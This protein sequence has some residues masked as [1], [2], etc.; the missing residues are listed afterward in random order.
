MF[1]GI[2]QFRSMI[3]RRFQQD[4]QTT[5]CENKA[6]IYWQL[7]MGEQKT[8]SVRR[9]KDKTYHGTSTDLLRPPGTDQI[10]TDASKYVCSG[11]LSQQCQDGKRRPVAY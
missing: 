10:E 9:I 1:P 11:I 7:G 3:Y 5:I 8:T 6:G 4:G 2:L